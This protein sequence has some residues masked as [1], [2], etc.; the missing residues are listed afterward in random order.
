[1]VK[2]TLP[3]KDG[4]RIRTNRTR[5]SA[6]SMDARNDSFQEDRDYKEILKDFISRPAVKYVAG[7]VAA[8][9]L[10]RLANNMAGKYPEISD[11]LRENMDNLEAKL[12]EFRDTL[13]N[14]A[15][16]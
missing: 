12:G 7:G 11:F 4:R 6:Q 10:A 2:K 15:Q 1:M 8:A 9:I 16:H 13:Q 14:T 3:K 5:G